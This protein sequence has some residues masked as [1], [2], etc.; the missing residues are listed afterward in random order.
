MEIKFQILNNK[1]LLRSKRVEIEIER[2]E[3][4]S[5]YSLKDKLLNYNLSS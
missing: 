3:F 1:L 2:Q 4:E 5:I